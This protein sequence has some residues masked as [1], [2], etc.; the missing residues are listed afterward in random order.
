M[1]VPESSSPPRLPP[2]ALPWLQGTASCLR[3]VGLLFAI[4][5]VLWAGLI[6]V[7]LGHVEEVFF[8]DVFGL[9]E[10]FGALCLLLIPLLLTAATAWQGS[11]RI[12]QFLKQP[13]QDR[14]FLLLAWQRW[15][16]YYLTLL[17]LVLALL[18][19]MWVAASPL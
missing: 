1:A 12:E 14:F 6:L 8:R 10:Y 3:L 4:A 11:K 5:G 19:L 18:A 13:D 7:L 16:Y 9:R 2:G 15:F 17:V